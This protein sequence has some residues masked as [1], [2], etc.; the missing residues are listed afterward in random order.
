VSGEFDPAG[1][2]LVE[3]R[4]FEELAVGERFPLPSRTLTAAHFS[5]F[6][7]LSGDN[8][9][10]H[11]DREYARA[12]GHDGL[13][14]HGLQVL[15]L[16]AAGAGL[17]PHVIG[18][19]LIGFL[20]VEARFVAPAREGDTLYP[21]LEIS[22]LTPQRTT[23]VVTMAATIHNQRG[24]LVLEGRQRYLLRLGDPADQR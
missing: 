4:A 17:F 9:P 8:H 22:E 16:S 3:V 19:A 10:I 5:A 1:H 23:G 6:Q 24:V 11:Y 21:M 13:L 20:D 15:S 18:P 7:A 2:R 12:H 14:A